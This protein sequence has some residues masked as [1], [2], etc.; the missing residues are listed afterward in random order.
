MHNINDEIE[1]IKNH[2]NENGKILIAVPNI[3]SVDARIFK[4]NWIAYD[5]PRHLY[6][7]I[8]VIKD[9]LNKHNIRINRT[10]PIIQDT[11][12]NIFLSLKDS[13]FFIKAFKLLFLS[14]YTFFIIKF[15]SKH[16][17]SNIYICT[18]K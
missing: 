6:H 1:I 9:L 3:D 14:I 18:I 12:F 16:S 11:F 8:I 5:A 17:S 2:L 7:L 15:N 4:D 13:F 10:T